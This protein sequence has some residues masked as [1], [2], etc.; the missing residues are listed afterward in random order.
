MK[1]IKKITALI[2][3]LTTLLFSF[4]LNGFANEE[5]EDENISACE[6]RLFKGKLVLYCS[7]A[8]MADDPHFVITHADEENEKICLEGDIWEI[9][10][11]YE[12]VVFDIDNDMFDPFETY[13][14][15]IYENEKEIC[16]KEFVPVDIGATSLE[17]VYDDYNF[18]EKEQIDLTEDILI[19]VNYNG[20]IRLSVGDT[21]C[22]EP[23]VRP[24][25]IDGFTV[26]AQ[27]QGN[28]YLYLYDEN[29]KEADK[30][31]FYVRERTADSFMEALEMS[32]SV[33]FESSMESAK[34]FLGLGISI[35]EFIVMP[36]M[37][38]VEVLAIMFKTL[39]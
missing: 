35:G 9:T 2:L 24:V 15:Y 16:M 37:V 4:S 7:D 18:L 32:T 33:F 31:W 34:N 6:V 11:T 25:S 13:R 20:E 39:F 22:P 10:Y 8:Y 5:T 28:G 38:I 12:K 36:F 26:T 21:Y 27:K 3:A 19:P 17:F 23:G 30:A 29:R 1:N 14:L